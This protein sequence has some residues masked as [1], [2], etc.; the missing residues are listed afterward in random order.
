[1]NTESHKK[2]TSFKGESLLTGLTENL[3]TRSSDLAENIVSLRLKL[4]GEPRVHH[5]TAR[6]ALCQIA[7]LHDTWLSSQQKFRH[8]L[9]SSF[10]SLYPLLIL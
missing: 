4:Y 3:L 1:M 5:S 10:T 8:D 7:I 2:N 6:A 9:C